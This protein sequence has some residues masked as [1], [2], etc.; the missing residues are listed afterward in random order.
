MSPELSYRL[1]V[2]SVLFNSA[3]EVFVAER[4]DM[5]GSWQ[6]PQGG[7]DKGEEPEAAVMRELEEEIG[8]DSAEIMACTEDW[9]SYDLPENLV[10][11]VWKGKYRGQKQLWYAMRFTG[12]DEDIDI[13]TKHPE[14]I[15]WKWVEFATISEL[16]VPF[17]REIYQEII[18]RF[19][20]LAG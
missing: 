18:T 7:I 10:G 12:L 4:I 2:G 16:I 11:K 14:F 19:R 3:G 6:M 8:T 20:H 15:R 17:K 5:P 1:G 13:N 9:L